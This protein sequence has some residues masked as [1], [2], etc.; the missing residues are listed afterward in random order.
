M[1]EVLFLFHRR[2]NRSLESL[3][4]SLSDD[5]LQRKGSIPVLMG[6][7]ETSGTT[8]LDLDP[9]GWEKSLWSREKVR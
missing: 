7:R 3:R 6:V 5:I 8:G 1:Q 9:G 4:A 2:G